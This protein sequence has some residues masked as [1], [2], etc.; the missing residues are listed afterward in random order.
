MNYSYL[1]AITCIGKT[2]LTQLNPMV[3]TVIKFD[4]LASYK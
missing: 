2:Q 4:T 1:A 3:Y